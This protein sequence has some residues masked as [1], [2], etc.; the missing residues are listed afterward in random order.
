VLPLAGCAASDDR[1]VREAEELRIFQ[2]PAGTAVDRIQPCTG[3]R[4]KAD[5]HPE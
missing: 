4:V 3:T 2:Q 5:G 1:E